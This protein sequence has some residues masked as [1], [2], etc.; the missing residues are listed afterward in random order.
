MGVRAGEYGR[1]FPERGL[2]NLAAVNRLVSGGA[3]TPHVG[4]TF[5]LDDTKQALNALIVRTIV[6]KAV[7]LQG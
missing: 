6:G 3:V 5:D 7:V 1:Q 2:A 4:Q